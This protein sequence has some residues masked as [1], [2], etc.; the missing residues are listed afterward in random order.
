MQN[1]AEF[2]I[3]GRLGRIH[4]MDKVTHLDLASNYRRKVDD[5]WQDDVYWNRVTLF[6][7]LHERAANLGAGDL[8]HITGRIRQSRFEK[9]GETIYAVDLIA[10]QMGTL[11][12][13]DVMAEQENPD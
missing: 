5:T 7:K 8:V 12:R 6:G 13:K 4:Q 1:I 2:R 10:N 9:D 3:I 11:L